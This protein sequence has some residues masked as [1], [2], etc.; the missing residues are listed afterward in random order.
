MRNSPTVTAKINT[1]PAEILT[2]VFE[3]SVPR[4]VHDHEQQF[5]FYDPTAVCAYWRRVAINAP[6][7]WTHIDAGTD[8]PAGLTN[9][10]LKRTKNS[11]ICVHVYE[12][13]YGYEPTPLETIEMTAKLLEPHMHR[14]CTLRIDSDSARTSLIVRVLNIWLDRGNK[15]LSRSLSVY[16]PRSN[17]PFLDAM[18]LGDSQIGFTLTK[19]GMNMLSSLSTLHL[20]GSLFYWDS[21][22]YQGLVDLRLD[23][24]SNN[25]ISITTSE[26]ATI[27]STNP[28]L[29]VL[30][31]GQL[32]V[33]QTASW[34]QPAP[35]LMNHLNVLDL[36][37]IDA[38]SSNRILSLVSLPTSSLSEVSLGLSARSGSLCNELES[39]LLRSGVATL[40]W[41]DTYDLKHFRLFQLPLPHQLPNIR[42]LVVNDVPFLGNSVLVETSPVYLPTVSPPHPLNITLLRC[43]VTFEG[44]SHLVVK[45]GI[46]QLQLE[47]C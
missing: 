18:T 44:L 40:Y 14:V 19:N 25:C 41:G 2:V 43:T 45:Y 6:Q 36:V 28:G 31:L 9:L 47:Q 4:C 39:F 46:Q 38:D 42:D 8:T 12:P 17:H 21:S 24:V 23:G 33:H 7:L 22:V 10:L 26:L 30:K 5:Q 37:K 32:D 13:N 27:L 35:T 20:H 1:L 15:D 3:M 29:V 16:C 11:A 34:N